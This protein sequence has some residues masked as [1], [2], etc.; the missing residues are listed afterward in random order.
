MPY[1]GPHPT[2]GLPNPLTRINA[3]ANA[4]VPRS[5]ACPDAGF[6]HASADS[7]RRNADA[8]ASVP[9]SSAPP[10][11]GYRHA[12]ADSN[13]R[14]TD[15]N[16]SVPRSSAP[17]D[18][19]YCHASADSNRCNANANASV[20][21]SSAPPDAGYRHASANSNRRNADANANVPRSSAC[22]DAGYRHASAD[23]N[24]PNA[25]ASP[26]TI[27]HGNGI[28][29]SGVDSGTGH[30][31]S[32]RQSS[33]K[34]DKR[35]LIPLSPL[36]I[37]LKPPTNQPSSS[38]PTVI[39]QEALQQHKKKN[40]DDGE[41]FD[42]TE[43]DTY[44]SDSNEDQVK[45]KAKKKLK[46]ETK[47][48][49]K[50]KSRDNQ[51]QE[52]EQ[53]QQQ[54]QQETAT[55][56]KAKAGKKR[57]RNDDDESG[58]EDRDSAPHKKRLPKSRSVVRD[59]N[60]GEESEEVYWN[61]DSSGEWPNSKF[62]TN[63]EYV[64]HAQ[65]ASNPCDKCRRARHWC[66]IFVGRKKVAC[67]R[68][69]RLRYKCSACADS[70]VAQLPTDVEPKALAGGKKPLEVSQERVKEKRMTSMKPPP[71]PIKKQPMQKHEGQSSLSYLFFDSFFVQ[72]RSTMPKEP[73]RLDPLDG[74]FNVRSSKPSIVALKP[75]RLNKELHNS[76]S[77]K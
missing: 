63:V 68:C 74:I 62:Y 30:F 70:R 55:G 45:T 9:R 54:Q 43:T 32:P 66:Y 71:I 77:I 7:N 59:N 25:N 49:C 18:A 72:E 60:S 40:T 6:C 5:S 12:S 27:R 53:Q 20:P 50:G 3:N 76:T 47:P 19:G 73:P 28:S 15:A 37:I 51:Q 1:N 52:Q 64:S 46:R 16:A 42:F 29:R 4:N 10:N 24:H 22:P 39:K 41:Y 34:P 67:R 26:Q 69:S 58:A 38:D 61:Y 13:R 23:S 31:G 57:H 11:A 14:N 33:S 65:P 35:D 75:S 21:R 36:R 2:N 56:I 17:P 44:S 48:D 8:N